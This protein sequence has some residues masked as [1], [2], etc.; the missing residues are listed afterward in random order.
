MKNLILN[1]TSIILLLVVSGCASSGKMFNYQN[2]NS[3]EI[4]KTTSAQAIQLVGTTKQIGTTSNKNGNFRVLKYVYAYATPS[5]AAARVLFLEF[6]NDTLNAQIYNSG[7]KEDKTSFNIDEAA[8]IKINESTKE[9]VLKLLGQPT[10]RAICPSTMGDF[11]NKCEKA[12]EVWAWIYTAKSAGYDT[13]TIISETL[14][15]SFDENGIASDF[16]T[17]RQ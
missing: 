11:A 12:F 8:K 14:I 13:S 6:K 3:L 5:G 17:M 9:D 2:R 10:G 1:S 15:I 7:F 16:A 4:G